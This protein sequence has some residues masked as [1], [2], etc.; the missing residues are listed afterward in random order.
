MR[1]IVIPR[2]DSRSLNETRGESLV[3]PYFVADTGNAIEFRGTLALLADDDGPDA[4]ALHVTGGEG[5]DAAQATRTKVDNMSSSLREGSRSRPVD[6]LD[7]DLVAERPSEG[8][9]ALAEI[10]A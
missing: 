5:T 7:E 1:T 4:A 2:R 3:P 8:L 6:R 9:I 10:R